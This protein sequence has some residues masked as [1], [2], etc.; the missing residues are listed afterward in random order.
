MQVETRILEFI[1]DNGETYFRCQYKYWRLWWYY[2]RYPCERGGGSVKVEFGNIE[3]AQKYI[4]EDLSEFRSKKK[5]FKRYIY[6]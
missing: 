6:K 3:D 2:R 4:E 5:W 1:D